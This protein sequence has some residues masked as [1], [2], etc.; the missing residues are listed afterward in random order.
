MHVAGRYPLV[1]DGR[2]RAERGQAR[3]V[4]LGGR[5]ALVWSQRPK[6]LLGLAFGVGCDQ[7]LV[8]VVTVE[9]L[10]LDRLEAVHVPA[11][12]ASGALA[13]ALP[14]LPKLGRGVGG[15]LV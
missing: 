4:N 10:G 1:R 9:A 7:Q 3:Q 11:E 6:H 13:L 2:V 14:S 15:G 5:R 12:Q 8:T